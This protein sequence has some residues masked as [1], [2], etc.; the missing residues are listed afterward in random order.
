M[1]YFSVFVLVAYFL[2]CIQ[3]DTLG[4]H[5]GPFRVS[6]VFLASFLFQDKLYFFIPKKVNFKPNRFFYHYHLIFL[7]AFYGN[8]LSLRLTD[9][10]WLDGSA[11]LY[12]VSHYSFGKFPELMSML[13]YGT[14][15]PKLLTYGGLAT[16]ILIILFLFHKKTRMYS[17]A[18]GILFHLLLMLIG[19]VYQWQFFL[20]GHFYILY[21][22]DKEML[23]T[24]INK[25]LYP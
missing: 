19:R 24:K 4:I 5:Q 25:K 16:Q 14:F 11:G 3:I 23:N 20:I 7:V 13:D 1:R 17:Y 18:L 15:I 8:M 9:S 10:R 2:V 22:M 12:V 6:V 21:L